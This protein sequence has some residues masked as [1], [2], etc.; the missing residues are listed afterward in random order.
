MYE[1]KNGWIFLAE[2]NLREGIEPRGRSAISME[3]IQIVMRAPQISSLLPESNSAA[4][5]LWVFEADK[6]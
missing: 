4:A 6:K 1:E 3:L 5:I 2:V